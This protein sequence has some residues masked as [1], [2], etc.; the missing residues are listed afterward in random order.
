MAAIA[1]SQFEQILKLRSQMTQI[2]FNSASLLAKPQN[3][4]S[5][6]SP[7]VEELMQSLKTFVKKNKNIT[8]S[9]E[10]KTVH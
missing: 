8:I 1:I 2:V 4:P 7:Y 10:F 3:C 9:Y 6:D 5:C